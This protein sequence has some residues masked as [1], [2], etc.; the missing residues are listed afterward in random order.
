MNRENLTVPVSLLLDQSLTPSARLIWICLNNPAR[1]HTPA[2]L[3]A[4]SG[5]SR[6]TILSG[7]A[8][9]SAQ[10]PASQPGPS[11]QIP[12][13]LLPSR[14][15]NPTAKLLYGVLQLTPSPA[16]T[17]YAEI[18]AISQLSLNTVKR[19]LADL[20]QE[21]W[22]DLTQ[23]SQR[24]PLAFTLLNPALQRREAALEAAVRRLARARFDG[25]AIMREYLNVLVDSDEFQDNVRPG[26]LTNP[27]T[28]ERME[29]DRYY[30]PHVALEFQGPQHDGPTKR[31]PSAEKARRQMGRDLIKEAIC[32]RRGI[33]LIPIHA[34]DLTPERLRQR[35][36]GLLPLR[37]DLT[38]HQQTLDY[39]KSI[40]RAYR[41]KARR[42]DPLPTGPTEPPKVPAKPS[43]CTE[44]SRPRR[45][46][47]RSIQ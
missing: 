2:Q 21:G 7:L 35:L 28:G 23:H 5:L 3:E 47:R 34:R 8:Q 24:A 6:G 16:T 26:L 40:G 39:L 12:P 42:P 19:A 33:R 18:A 14:R 9:L 45:N 44:S 25:E 4:G 15:L 22:L 1:A 31:Y 38:E 13:D 10:A 20:C 32:A 29:F 11:V 27:Y 43:L 36:Q 17:S 41:Y 30:P 46:R 37:Q